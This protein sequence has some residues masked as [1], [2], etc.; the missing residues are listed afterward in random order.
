[1]SLRHR[2]K[3]FLRHQLWSWQ[4]LLTLRRHRDV[5]V[6]FHD[7]TTPPS[8]HPSELCRCE[9]YSSMMR[10]KTSESVPFDA[11]TGHLLDC[12]WAAVM[13]RTC[14]GAGYCRECGGEGVDPTSSQQEPILSPALCLK[15]EQP[16]DG[17]DH[18][19]CFQ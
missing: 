3:W 13:C 19:E 2:I 17:G 14:R 6:S 10:D 4:R 5:A 7:F 8:I 11:N 12:E 1:M 18:A 16:L 15:C 9:A